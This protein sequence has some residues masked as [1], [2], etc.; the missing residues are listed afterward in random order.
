MNKFLTIILVSFI[1]LNSYSQGETEPYESKKWMVKSILFSQPFVYKPKNPLPNFFT[2]I[3]I[4]RYFGDVGARFSFERMVNNSTQ[5]FHDSNTVATR[6]GNFEENVFRV[7]SEYKKNYYD[8]MSLHFFVDYIFTIFEGETN[9]TTDLGIA[10]YHQKVK[11][12]T[13]GAV[14]GMGFDCLLSEHFSF[15]FET[16][17]EILNNSGNYYRN[18]YL[19]N[20][21]ITYFDS[22]N[23]LNLKLL[24]NL[25]LNYHF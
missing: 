21:S 24:G 20:H 5:L 2:G 15:G 12:N 22:N 14:I 23:E 13:H 11:G 4:N 1:S 19:R 18:N 9:E 17:F 10:L 6:L 8:F 3:G 16:R 7:G 25:S